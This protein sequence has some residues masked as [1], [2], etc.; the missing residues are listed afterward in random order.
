VRHAVIGVWADRR[1]GVRVEPPSEQHHAKGSV[2][3]VLQVPD[4]AALA[5][6]EEVARPVRAMV[7][8]RR[9]FRMSSRSPG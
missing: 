7:M 9:T 6:T 4:G 2:S 1:G 5:R 8:T 3:I